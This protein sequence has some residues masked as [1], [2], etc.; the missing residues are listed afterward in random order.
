[1]KRCFGE[2]KK[3]RYVARIT[4]WAFLALVLES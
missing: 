4:G 3:N 1:M 2:K